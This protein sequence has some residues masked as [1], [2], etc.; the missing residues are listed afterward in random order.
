MTQAM[1]EKQELLVA[2]E[3]GQVFSFSID[4]DMLP[5][6]REQMTV[7]DSTSLESK[8]PG[9]ECATLR[10]LCAG[11]LPEEGC[12]TIGFVV[13]SRVRNKQKTHFKLVRGLDLQCLPARGR[14]DA[15]LRSCGFKPRFAN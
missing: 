5:K 13:I 1:Q 14:V 3:N 10:A 4:E 8:F 12:A 9:E 7:F 11:L 2:E 6:H 15:A